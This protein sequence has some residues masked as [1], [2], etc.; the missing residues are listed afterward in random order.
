MILAN[1][2]TELLH[3]ERKASD[4][5]NTAVKTFEQGGI[6]KNLPTIKIKKQNIVSGIGILDLLSLTKIMSSK[7]E[8]RRAI[9]NNGIKINDIILSDVHKQINLSV[10]GEN[11]FIKISFGKK[12]HFLIKIY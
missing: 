10:F 4:A 6:G 9:A 8:A 11:N 1:K 7:S 3:G 2:A 12:K 5:E